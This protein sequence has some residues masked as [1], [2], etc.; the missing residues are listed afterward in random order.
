[1]DCTERDFGTTRARA[2]FPTRL[3]EC[4]QIAAILN[5]QAR[6]TVVIVGGLTYEPVERQQICRTLLQKYLF[7]LA[8]EC[9]AVIVSRGYSISNQ[10]L[11]DLPLLI[12]SIAAA[13]RE[14]PVV[15]TALRIGVWYPGAELKEGESYM[16]GPH[17]TDHVLVP[18]ASEREASTWRT[19]LVSS[20]MAR[21]TEREATQPGVTLVL[22]GTTAAWYDVLSSINHERH[23]VTMAKPHSCGTNR[24]IADYLRTGRHDPPFIADLRASMAQTQ[25]KHTTRNQLHAFPCEQPE[26]LAALLRKLLVNAQ[27]PSAPQPRS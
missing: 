20:F 25:A 10:P 27:H 2:L 7:P 11:E 6:P 19:A 21:L 9:G 8:R 1:M 24:E 3:E 13:W 16:P 26:R 17:H 22:G 4:E 15:C 23:V 18:G 5:Y 14:T 12:D